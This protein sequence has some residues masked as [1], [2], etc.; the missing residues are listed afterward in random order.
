MINDLLCGAV[1]P[2]VPNYIP[3]EWQRRLLDVVDRN[4][5]ALVSAP[6]SS[7]KSFVAFYCMSKCLRKN[8]SDVCVYVAP[9][10]A[11]VNQVYIDVIG[12]FRKSYKKGQL[13]ASWTRDQKSCRDPLTAQILVTVPQILEMLCLSALQN[14]STGWV[15]RIRWIIFDE[16]HQMSAEGSNAEWESLLVL[17]PAPFVALSATLGNTDHFHSWLKV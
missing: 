6:T 8:D 4:H 1:D 10:K 2:R 5:S 15:S 3:D 16:V 12:R 17:S 7:G 14:S 9:T 11:L 13:V